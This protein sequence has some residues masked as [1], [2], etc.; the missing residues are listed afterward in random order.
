MPGRGSPPTPR[1]PGRSQVWEPKPYVR[2]VPKLFEHLRSKL[3]DQVELLHDV[4]ERVSPNQAVQFAKAVEPFR[5][6]FLEDPLSPEDIA[7]FR[8]MRQQCATPI[9]MGEL[10]NSPHEWVGLI[11]ERLIDFI[12]WASDLQTMHRCCTSETRD[13][14]TCKDVLKIFTPACPAGERYQVESYFPSGKM[15]IARGVTTGTRIRRPTVRLVTCGITCGCEYISTSSLAASI[16]CVARRA[17]WDLIYDLASQ[18][19]TLMV[20]THY[21]DEAE[22]LCDQVA[23]MSS[24]RV[25]GAGAPADLIALLAPET[26]E[27][28]CSP[29]EETALLDGIAPAARRLRIGQRVMLYLEDPT[30]VIARIR[31]RGL[32]QGQLGAH[33]V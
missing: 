32:V 18:G 3:G 24:G 20:T 6:F 5:L 12:R 11:S 10:F 16:S 33:A 15:F 19:V 8:Q 25:I 22:R 30:S 21:M 2:L 27:F 28:D 23:I 31:G 17:F 14:G 13:C 9:A 1:A 29:D 4:H 26:I 7:W